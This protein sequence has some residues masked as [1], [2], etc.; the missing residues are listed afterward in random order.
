M[1]VKPSP[2]IEAIVRRFTEAGARGDIDVAKKFYSDSKDLRSIGTDEHEW[3]RGPQEAMPLME[4]HAREA[5]TYESELLR[6]EA[7]EEGSVGWAAYEQRTTSFTGRSVVYRRT[8]VLELESG[9]WK[10]VHTHVSVPVPN[11]ETEG[12]ELT[13]TLADLVGSIHADADFSPA[14]GLSGTATLMFTDIVD[15]TPLSLS[16]GEAVWMDTISTHFDALQ[17]VVES[18]GG[19]VVKTLGD[20]G[21]YAFESGSAALSAAKKI[22]QTVTAGPEPRFQ[23]R[24][25]VHTGDVMQ[26]ERDYVGA[27][28]AKAARV[29]A[30][31]DGGQVL[32][33]STTAGLVNPAEF[34]FGSPI[35]VELKG[36]DGTHQLQ[37]L[38]W[39]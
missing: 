17:R 33:S 16:L 5:G 22:Q 30:A 26:T 13:R 7:F 32:V 36:M 29:A 6:L 25:G 19:S 4:A 21:M 28:V 9:M 24:V 35:T 23:V 2:E 18:E 31:A 38:I 10:I 8:L 39:S 37:P 15:S 1:L 11:L 14:A 27:T 12:F 20:G 34:E 3:Y